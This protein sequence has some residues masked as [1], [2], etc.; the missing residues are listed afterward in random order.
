MHKNSDKTNKSDGNSVV[1]LGESLRADLGKGE[2]VLHFDSVSI[3]IGKGG[4]PFKLIADPQFDLERLA[5]KAGENL[6]NIKFVYVQTFSG[7]EVFRKA[8]DQ[9]AKNLKEFKNLELLSLGKVTV[10]DLHAFAGF[11]ISYLILEKVSMSDKTR[12]IESLN[13]IQDLQILVHDFSLDADEINL[14]N[15]VAPNVSVVDSKEFERRLT[16]GEIRLD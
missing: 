3:L 13:E 16:A 10:K 7:E 8:I 15:S 9:V 1:D 14:I 4:V 2:S 11:R 6:Y 5:S 12:F